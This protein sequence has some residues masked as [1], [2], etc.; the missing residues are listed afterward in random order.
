ML[1]ITS[2]QLRKM[3]LT[4]RIMRSVTRRFHLSILHLSENIHDE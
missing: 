1:A 4:R 2:P 3:G